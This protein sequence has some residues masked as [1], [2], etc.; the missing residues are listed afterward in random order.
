[1]GE[2]HSD[3]GGPTVIDHDVISDLTV[4]TAKK[5]KDKWL[6]L[7]HRLKQQIEKW[8]RSGQGDGGYIEDD[9]FG[10]EED[11]TRPAP[12]IGELSNPSQGALDSCAV[13]FRDKESYLLYLWEVLE[14]NGLL[15][16]SM[17][18]L[19]S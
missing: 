7:L 12:K 19:N 16:L 3:F 17:Q 2:L 18:R 15:V 14:G 11:E 5:V 9:S 4:T 1:M 6:E 8:E 10:D 13:F